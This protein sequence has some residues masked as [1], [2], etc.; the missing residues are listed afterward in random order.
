MTK[1]VEQADVIVLGMGPGSEDVAGR[2]ALAKLDVIGID[3]RLLGGECPYWGCIP[4]KIM[5]RSSDLVAEARR[6]ADMTGSVTDRPDWQPVVG[7]VREAT[8][9][10]DDGVAVH[11]F[12]GKGGRL[13]RG[14]G[15]LD[16]PGRVV[17]DDLTF[18]ARRA[19]VLATGSRPT[20]PPI[21]GLDDTPYWT[22]R[23][24][25][26]SD[27]VPESLIVL[28]GGAVGLELAQVFRRFGA[29]VTVLDTA[30]R[31][32]IG[33]EPETGDLIA[34]VLESEGI[35]VRLEVG[36]SSVYHDGTRFILVLDGGEALGAQRLLVATG[37]HADLAA[38][39]LS[40]IGVDE[41]LRAVPVDDRLRVPGVDATWAVGDLTGKGAFTHT[42]MYQ[43]DLA[44][45]DILGQTA[46]PADYR[47]MPRVTFTDPEIGAVGLTE[48]AARDAG[49]SVHVG[50]TDL[51]ASARGWIHGAGQG[52]IKLV[53]DTDRRVLVGAT[54]IGPDGGEVLGLL[55]LAVH[56][57]VPVPTLADMIFAYPTFHRAIQE[58]VRDLA[59]A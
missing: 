50:A 52:L 41:E 29:E 53:A 38:L 43:A 31:L 28:G 19:V 6:G 20:I 1:Q 13:R 11:R 2:L 12:G 56:A 8:D 24:A 33:E 17:V 3:G 35:A 18:V 48:R 51:S 9:G 36:V 55:A 21:P 27:R 49:L 44:V 14:A 34:E 10:W 32:L 25:V 30:P 22:N 4:S 46:P 58:A 15:R 7:R 26:M 39:H 45:R 40:S 23:E 16:G 42:A 59:L 37:R 5:V 57:A 47:A 54:S